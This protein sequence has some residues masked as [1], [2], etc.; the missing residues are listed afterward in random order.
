M[1]IGHEWMSFLQSLCDSYLT[2]LP[3]DTPDID[4]RE[5]DLL[6]PVGANPRRVWVRVAAPPDAHGAWMNRRLWISCPLSIMGIGPPGPS[7]SA[8]CTQVR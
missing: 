5:A 1:T 4:G 8:L 3:F 6:L 7:R 2:A